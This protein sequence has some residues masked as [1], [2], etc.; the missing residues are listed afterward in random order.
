MQILR[1]D[2][3][4]SA[5]VSS[6][7]F[8]FPM[9]QSNTTW[10]VIVYRSPDTVP[11]GQTIDSPQSGP[12][13]TEVVVFSVS[14]GVIGGLSPRQV[15]S[16]VDKAVRAALHGYKD[17]VVIDSSPQEMIDIQGIFFTRGADGHDDASQT[18]QYL[19]VFSVRYS[20]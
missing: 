14:K 5:L 3:D 12:P 19:S 8:E 4:V 11:E 7:I 15:S 17:V 2:A 10:P 6:R 9:S 1:D 13:D 20:E 16:R 18:Y